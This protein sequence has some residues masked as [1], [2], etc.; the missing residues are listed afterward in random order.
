[1]EYSKLI[2]LCGARDFHAIDWYRSAEEQLN[3]E[4][5]CILTD[6]I[7]GE[8]FQ[9]IVSEDDNVYSLIILDKLLFRGQSNIGN[10][11]RNIL[12]L[13]MLP[14]QIILIKKFNKRNPN[15]IYHVHSMYY[16]WLAAGANIDFVG[17]PQGSDILVKPFKSKI[18]KTLSIWALR[19]AKY[20]TVDSKKMRDKVFEISG[21]EAKIIQNGIDIKAIGGGRIFTSKKVLIRDRLVSIRGFSPLYR[22]EELF[23][24]RNIENNAKD[25]PISL[26]YPFYENKYKQKILKYLT[27]NDEDLGRV[28]RTQMYELLFESQL[29]ISIPSS[30]SSP[31]SVYEAIFC[32]S[33][34][35]ITYHPYYDT[36]PI[37]M[38]ERI[39]LV[40]L[41]NENW[42]LNATKDAN[43]I[44]TSYFIPCEKALDLF[45]QRRS[46][47]RILSLINE[48]N[49][50]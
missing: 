25:F 13:L 33:A 18:Y 20:I 34:V 22:I 3:K 4:N 40:D 41:D 24:A 36:L 23:I 11:W 38:K 9:K 50:E 12:K 27:A 1:M 21:I 44:I 15:S 19:S 31:R 2:F 7:A 16:L 5:L 37:C 39:I 29:V 35:A 48:S 10:L 26:I 46:F 8:G 14:L 30:D 17:T 32:G 49:C 42:L 28:N 45:D 47:K 43:L 6:L